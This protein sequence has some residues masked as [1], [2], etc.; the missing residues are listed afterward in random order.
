MAGCYWWLPTW[1]NTWCAKINF[2]APVAKCQVPLCENTANPEQ[3][4][5]VTFNMRNRKSLTFQRTVP[6]P[7]WVS[8]NFWRSLSFY[9]K[10]PPSN[11]HFTSLKWNYL[12]SSTWFRHIFLIWLQNKKMS[13]G[14]MQRAWY[15]SNSLHW[16][17]AC[18]HSWEKFDIFIFF[19]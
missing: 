16:I 17:G 9:N 7:A 10:F 11:W 14:C 12:Y 4:S 5:A 18:L 8:K 1:Q 13:T 15:S 6:G 3:D 2:I 19:R